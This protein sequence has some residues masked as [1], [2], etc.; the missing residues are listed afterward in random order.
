MQTALIAFDVVA[1]INR[2]NVD[3]RSI[4]REYALDENEISA[5]EL[6]RIVKKL[7]FKAKIKK[8]TSMD[9]L[10]NYPFPAIIMKC[11]GSYDVLLKTDKE[12]QRVLIFSI[13]ENKTKDFEFA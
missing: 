6:L 1:K 4:V 3:I 2:I 9:T 12:K 10:S 5:D 8:I 7:E 13:S 11:D